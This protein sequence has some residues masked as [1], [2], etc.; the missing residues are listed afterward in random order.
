MSNVEQAA[1]R[2]QAQKKLARRRHDIIDGN[3]KSYAKVLNSDERME[4]VMDYNNLQAAIAE[5]NVERD[6]DKK[7]KQ[8]EKDEKK[9]EK[10]R[11]EVEKKIATENEKIEKMPGILEDIAKGLGHLNTMKAPRLRDILVFYFKYSIGEVRNAK[12]AELINM[13]NNEMAGVSANT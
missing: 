5:I 3:R 11:K 4:K 2:V 8:K 12:K 10:E 7:K 9:K 13:M 6:E 1:Y